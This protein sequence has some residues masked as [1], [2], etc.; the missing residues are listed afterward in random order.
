VK[1]TIFSL[2]GKILI[3]ILGGKHKITANVIYLPNNAIWCWFTGITSEEAG[4][5]R[6]KEVA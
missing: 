6:R 1:I 2:F 3:D 5:R 4:K